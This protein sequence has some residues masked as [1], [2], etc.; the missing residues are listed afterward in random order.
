MGR[1]VEALRR[2]DFTRYSTD[3]V[4]EGEWRPDAVVLEEPE[5]LNWYSFVEGH[6][7][8]GVRPR[9]M[10]LVLY[11]RIMSDML[12]QK[13]CAPVRSGTWSHPIVGPHKACAALLMARWMTN[14]HCHRI[15]KL[16]GTLPR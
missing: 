12:Q 10:W 13:G 6:S 5:H 3:N 11:T 1:T 2:S 15:V 9:I 16:S 7:S 8:V 4:E 14:G